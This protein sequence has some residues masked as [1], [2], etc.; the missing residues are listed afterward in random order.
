MCIKNNSCGTH[1]RGLWNHW[2][3][4]KSRPSTR[5]KLFVIL[6]EAP[7][8]APWPGG[9]NVEDV[10]PSYGRVWAP[11]PEIFQDHKDH[12]IAIVKALRRPS[13]LAIPTYSYH[14]NPCP[15]SSPF[16]RVGSF[17]CV[18]VACSAHTL[19]LQMLYMHK[20]MLVHHRPHKETT[21]LDWVCI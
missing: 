12:M 20:A 3:I 13:M 14:A 19:R 10:A 11:R 6:P 4:S 8:E 7:S 9:E 5:L 1:V 21:C 18:I 17:W 16:L 2:K 15:I